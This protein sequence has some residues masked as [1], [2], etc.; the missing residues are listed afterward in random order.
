MKTTFLLLCAALCG[1]VAGAHSHELSTAS[2]SVADSVAQVATKASDKQ[3]ESRTPF[4]PSV[5]LGGYIT[6]KYEMT[7]REG[8][9]TS[10]NFSMRYFRFYGSGYAWRDVFYRFQMEMSGAPGID[11]GPRLLDAYVEWRK[12]S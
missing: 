1:G 5:T 7:D 12:I 8:A 6:S 10:S 3:P 11:R 2:A 9:A 4:K